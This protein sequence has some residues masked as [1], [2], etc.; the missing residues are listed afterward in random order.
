M[1]LIRI[2]GIAATKEELIKSK[3][4]FKIGH[5]VLCVDDRFDRQPAHA[6]KLGEVYTIQ[7]FY[8]C[9]SCGSLQYSLFEFHFYTLMGCRC[10][11]TLYRRQ[12]FYAWRFVS[13][14]DQENIAEVPEE[15]LVVS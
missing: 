2:E 10:G 9:P 12:T 5:K 1:N 8:R 7:G 6:V 11:H 14:E 4:G 15:E 3:M 13:I